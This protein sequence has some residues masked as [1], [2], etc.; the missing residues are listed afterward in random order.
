MKHNRLINEKSLYLR[1][2]ANNPVDWYPW[3]EEAFARARQ[4]DKPIFLSIGY[5]SCH[6]CHVMEEESFMDTEVAEMMNRLFVSIKVDR[7]ERPDIDAIFMNVCQAMTG[8]GGW[9]LTVFLTPDGKP[10]FA[11]TYFPKTTRW[12]K[13]GLIELISNVERLW[14][15]KRSEIEKATLSF[16]NYLRLQKPKPTEITLDAD[17]FANVFE[18]LSF[19][20]DR[21]YGGFGSAPKFPMPSN[22]IFLLDYYKYRNEPQALTMVETTLKQM[23]LGGIFDQV[24]FGFHRY[25]TD[26]FWRLPHFEKMLYDQALLLLVYSKAFLVTKN[27]FYR[28]VADEIFGYLMEN[29][30]SEQGAL[31]SSEDADSEGEEGKYYLFTYQELSDV[32]TEDFELFCKV[33]NVSA[34]GN[35][36]S[37]ESSHRNKNI[38]FM[39]RLPSELAVSLNIDESEL[40][41]K[42]NKF[43][44]QL[45]NYTANRIKPMRD[46]KILADWNGLT[47]AGL[48]YYYRTNFDSKVKDLIEKY[49]IFFV[50]N[51]LQADGSIRH[52]YYNSESYIDGMIEDYAF[53]SWGFWE[54]YQST[55][56]GRYL[57]MA[58]ELFNR[59]VNDFWDNDEGGFFVSNKNQT[60]LFINPKEFFDG[61][62]PSANSVMYYLANIFYRLTGKQL[63]NKLADWLLDVFKTYLA[64]NSSAH[65]YM[66]FAI[67]QNLIE[68][69]EIVFVYENPNSIENY[70]RLIFSEYLHR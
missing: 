8:S 68:S 57:T 59:A 61:A 3:C 64:E 35:F 32:I 1:Q 53:T 55:G 11:G 6:W 16:E 4:E 19:S 45:R 66:N 26:Q 52:S 17:Y 51:I 37:F 7:E 28:K 31:Y 69:Q 21:T 38:L 50:Q 27:E 56:D 15:E 46:E 36:T 9:P 48:S 67:L 34:E 62:I 23:R 41:N 54:A 43:I 39:T 49:F 24:H 30:Y 63:Y 22:L 25:S 44:N 2:H 18:I 14:K 70:R 65:N 33:F 58:I 5:S 40:Q 10:F 20:F 47:L 60:E 12:G 42:I 29:L 13:I